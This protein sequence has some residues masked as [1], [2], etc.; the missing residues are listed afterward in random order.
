MKSFNR[1]LM[2]VTLPALPIFQSCSEKDNLTPL[3][4]ATYP[5]IPLKLFIADG[6]IDRLESLVQNEDGSYTLKTKDG[7]ADWPFDEN[8]R[9]SFPG[10]HATDEWT[11]VR[12][13]VKLLFE[14]GFGK[15][16]DMFRD[17]KISVSLVD[18][19]HAGHHIQKSGSAGRLDSQKGK[20]IQRLNAEKSMAFGSRSRLRH[21][22]QCSQF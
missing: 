20:P 6:W 7:A 12:F 18:G 5:D 16:F 22:I 2:A 17:G 9:R 15:K 3:K 1:I 19:N 21:G 11:E 8:V 13:N 10:F 14:L 4:P